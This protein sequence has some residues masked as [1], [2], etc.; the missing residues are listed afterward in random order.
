MSKKII[1]HCSGCNTR[2]HI[3]P[4]KNQLC[5]SCKAI[6]H[7]I[8]GDGKWLWRRLNKKFG[9]VKRAAFKLGR[10]AAFKAVRAANLEVAKEEKRLKE[11]GLW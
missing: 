2:N 6:I 11:V 4:N 10:I 5:R 1:I 8:P 3:N 7:E 9:Q